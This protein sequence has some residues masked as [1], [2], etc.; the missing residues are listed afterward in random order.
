MTSVDIGRQP[1][2]VFYTSALANQGVAPEL[3]M[4]LTGHETEAAHRGYTHH[5]LEKLRA[6]RKKSSRQAE[7]NFRPLDVVKHS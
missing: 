2:A 7:F 5:E 6:A 1:A 4:K 3:R